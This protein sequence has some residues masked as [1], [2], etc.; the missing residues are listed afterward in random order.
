VAHIQFFTA[1]SPEQVAFN[2]ENF[3]GAEGRDSFAVAGAW[4]PFPVRESS[5]TCSNSDL[6]I[7]DHRR[8]KQRHGG[9]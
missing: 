9:F 8:S 1:L 2:A 3:V 5:K 6:G 4:L 7:P